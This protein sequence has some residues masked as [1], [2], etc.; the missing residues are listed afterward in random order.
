M[1]VFKRNMRKVRQ[2]ILLDAW[3]TLD[4]GF[5]KRPCTVLDLSATGARLEVQNAEKLGSRLGLALTKDVRKLTPCRMVWQ[6][7]SEIGVEFVAAA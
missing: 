1:A 7:G 6:K 4:G 2:Q 3:L 5:A